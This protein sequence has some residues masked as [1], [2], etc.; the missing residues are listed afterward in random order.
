[1]NNFFIII[2]SCEPTSKTKTEPMLKF[3]Q[4]IRKL[5]LEVRL[6]V[7]ISTTN[8]YF[9]LNKIKRPSCI[10]QLI[11]TSQNVVLVETGYNSFR[12]NKS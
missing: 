8:E 2:W 1:M 3:L 11:P 4:L 10:N 6:D 7:P 5:E 12:F 9:T